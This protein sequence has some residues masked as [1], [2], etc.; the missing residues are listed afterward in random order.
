MPKQ[1]IEFVIKPDGTVEERVTGVSG[2]DCEKVT[3]AIERALGD[4]TKR[5]HT[6][7]YYD[8]SQSS[9]QT[10]STGS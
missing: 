8:E 6:S 4:V 10:V 3:E 5:E 7:D 1:E 2:P 9:G